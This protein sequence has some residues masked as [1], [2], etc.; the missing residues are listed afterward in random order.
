MGVGQAPDRSRSRGPAKEG[1]GRTV[2]V[3][4]RTLRAQ[5]ASGVPSPHG[6]ERELLPRAA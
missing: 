3:F 4:H 5:E 1:G 2:R 6:L